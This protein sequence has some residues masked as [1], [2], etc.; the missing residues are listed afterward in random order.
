LVYTYNDHDEHF[1][2]AALYFG[3]GITTVV[4]SYFFYSFV[5]N[6]IVEVWKAFSWMQ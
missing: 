5:Q 1:F 4:L 6:T 2:A 3:S